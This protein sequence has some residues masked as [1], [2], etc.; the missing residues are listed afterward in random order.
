MNLWDPPD[1]PNLLDLPDLSDLSDPPDLPNLR[2]V[3]PTIWRCCGLRACC[4]GGD[5]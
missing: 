2:Y 1:L 5:V 4:C 3:V